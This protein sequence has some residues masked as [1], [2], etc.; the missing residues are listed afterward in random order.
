[1]PACRGCTYTT[2]RPPRRGLTGKIR[3]AS[4]VT[5]RTWTRLPPPHCRPHNGNYTPPRQL[6]QVSP[7]GSR[8]RQRVADSRQRNRNSQTGG[9]LDQN[10]PR[11]WRDG[12]ALA[13]GFG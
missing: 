6:R 3:S 10:P 11:K 9:A 2:H 5:I 13:C 7:R 4:D 8:A 12:A 1:M